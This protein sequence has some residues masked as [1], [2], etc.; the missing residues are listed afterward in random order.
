MV[1]M[2]GSVGRLLPDLWSL[3][4]GHGTKDVQSGDMVHRAGSFN[5][6]PRHL[7]P[8]RASRAKAPVWI[9]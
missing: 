1:E 7:P 5:K 8:P 2:L 9:I 4:G 3:V 6:E